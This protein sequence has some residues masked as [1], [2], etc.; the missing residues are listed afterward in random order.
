MYT[1]DVTTGEDAVGAD[2]GHVA[3]RSEQRQRK[4]PRADAD[5][6]SPQGQQLII[7][8]RAHLATGTSGRYQEAL[9]RA[10]KL[11][12][13]ERAALLPALANMI[14]QDQAKSLQ[15]LAQSIGVAEHFAAEALANKPSE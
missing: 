1:L 12:P 2:A 5:V 10:T 14:Q 11:T 7:E 15:L 3:K 8:A 13:T 9:K 4:R 6:L